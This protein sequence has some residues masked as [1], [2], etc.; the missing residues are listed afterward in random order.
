MTLTRTN[1]NTYQ[2]E[3]ESMDNENDIWQ[4]KT[5]T[6]PECN[7]VT[8]HDLNGW[9]CTYCGLHL[10]VNHNWNKQRKNK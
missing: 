1:I 5:G 10:D 2:K 7:S 6:C 4:M 9:T 8:E 3:R